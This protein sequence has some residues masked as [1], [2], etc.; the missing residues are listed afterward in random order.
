MTEPDPSSP[1]ID[2]RDCICRSERRWMGDGRKVLLLLHH[3]AQK[4]SIL[5]FD[6]QRCVGRMSEDVIY[7]IGIR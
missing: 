1:G 2:W 6:R 3:V 5:V 7:Q 4:N